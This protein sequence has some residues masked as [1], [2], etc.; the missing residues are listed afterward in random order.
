[1]LTTRITRIVTSVLLLHVVVLWALQSGLVLRI[2]NLVTPAEVIV[3]IVAP[4]ETAPVRAAPRVEQRTT[5]SP[6]H[7]EVEV[8]RPAPS[9]LVISQP[10]AVAVEQTYVPTAPVTAPSAS[11]NNIAAASPTATVAAPPALVM[12]STDADYLHN[13]KP[14]YPPLSKRL[15]EE[16]KVV[17]RTLIGADGNAQQAEVKQS[18]GFDRLDEAARTTALRW[19]YVPGKRVGVAQAMWFDVP[20]TFV[21]E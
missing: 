16:G 3:E 13:T 17:V 10:D 11:A 12:P 2:A 8:A 15:R 20:F 5:A 6:A 7:T 21:L 9:A 4:E 14:A 18:S 19:R 1:M